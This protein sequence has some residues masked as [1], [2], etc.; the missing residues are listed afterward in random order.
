MLGAARGREP[1]SGEADDAPLGRARLVAGRDHCVLD[2]IE[3]PG[4]TLRDKPFLLWEGNRLPRLV[5]AFDG[6]LLDAAAAGLH[7]TIDRLVARV[8]GER[9]G[10]RKRGET[11]ERWD[12]AEPVLTGGGG[13][14]VG[15]GVTEEWRDP[16]FEPGSARPA[17]E[18]RDVCR[19][20]SALATEIGPRFVS[21]DY[22]I[23]IQPL[24]PPLWHLNGGRRV[25]VALVPRGRRTPDGPLEGFGLDAVG[26]GLRPWAALAALE[27][28]RRM[29]RPGTTSL[30]LL[31]EPE[32][33][34]HPIAQRAAARFVAESVDQ[35][36]SV[37][38]CTHSPAFLSERIP[39][40]ELVRLSRERGATRAFLVPAGRLDAVE[41][42]LEAFGLTRGDLL[43]LTRGVLLVE[44]RHDRLVLRSFFGED[45][46]DAFVRVLI[47]SGSDN[48]SAVVEALRGLPITLFVMLDGVSSEL[49]ESLGT[50]RITGR[51]RA[52]EQRQIAS[53]VV[54][55]LVDASRVVAFDAP[56]IVWA[57]PEEAVRTAAPTF[58]GWEAALA[59]FRAEPER[60]NP[61]E[62]LRRRYGLDV[63]EGSLARMV[64][65]AKERGLPP[66]RRLK[67]AVSR[68]LDA[69]DPRREGS[70]AR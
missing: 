38:L 6:R 9:A 26:A 51:E 22:A 20:A 56:D 41:R 61:K 30:L 33:H 25:R 50:G 62:F 8:A 19:E 46:A 53:L 15:P 42:D 3:L 63:T 16:W 27:A 58:P 13:V 11:W 65:V 57:L 17:A 12:P 4:V 10:W 32:R 31:D 36:A 5:D 54:S 35:G 66:N 70:A 64:A 48:A 40:S 49:V 2:G 24:E 55:G 29:E 21:D 28:L 18:I 44:G 45:L 52:K 68:V 14:V 7:D 69:V 47:V 1:V 34:L 37:V 43:A 39:S 67:E 23:R 60:M 59:A